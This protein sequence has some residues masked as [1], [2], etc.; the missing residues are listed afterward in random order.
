MLSI[1]FLEL[2]KWDSFWWWITYYKKKLRDFWKGCVNSTKST[3]LT[4]GETDWQPEWQD[5]AI[6]G[7]GSYNHIIVDVKTKECWGPCHGASDSALSLPLMQFQQLVV[8]KGPLG[9][10]TLLSKKHSQKKKP[11]IYFIFDTQLSQSP[12]LCQMKNDR[13][14]FPQIKIYYWE[15]MKY[16][17]STLRRSSIVHLTW[18]CP[19][20]CMSPAAVLS[21][22]G[23]KCVYKFRWP[24]IREYV[25][26]HVKL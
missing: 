1:D 8:K 14:L 19:K 3:N 4:R 18:F 6:I 20:Y 9:A 7:L 15:I 5:K 10:I 13:L 25:S 16:C 24:W 12:I 17:H 22:R 26:F 23:L 11:Y 2:L 21:Q